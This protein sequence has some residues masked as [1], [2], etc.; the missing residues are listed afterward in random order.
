MVSVSCSG[1]ELKRKER[2]MGTEPYKLVIYSHASGSLMF[3][4]IA[5]LL[6]SPQLRK[7]GVHNSTAEVSCRLRLLQPL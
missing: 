3:L 1:E 7:L 6:S 5:D 4:D 2:E